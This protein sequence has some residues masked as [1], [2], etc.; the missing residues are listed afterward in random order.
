MKTLFAYLDLLG[1]KDLI[2]HHTS[3]ELRRIIKQFV[4]QLNDS[5]M[6]SREYSAINSQG[7]VIL[8]Y[9]KIDDI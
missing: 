6:K 2:L 5:V 1:F 3:L 4:Q 9:E 8:G 7:D